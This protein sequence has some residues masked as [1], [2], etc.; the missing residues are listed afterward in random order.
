[1]TAVIIEVFTRE[2]PAVA[3]KLPAE[4]MLPLLTM[5]LTALRTKLKLLTKEFISMPS[6]EKPDEGNIE[7][8][9]PLLK[10]LLALNKPEV[11]DE[12]VEMA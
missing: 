5:L 1:M 12:F 6:P 2:V 11:T 9:K 4:V 3:V 10:M 8:S 7:V